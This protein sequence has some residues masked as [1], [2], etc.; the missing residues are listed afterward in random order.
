[1]GK[2][3]AGKS[4]G[5]HKL[6]AAALLLLLA[7][8]GV[9]KNTP[10]TI[11]YACDDST[12]AIIALS[13]QRDR[14]RLEIGEF[15]YDLQAIESDSGIKYSDDQILYWSKGDEAT[16]SGAALLNP[17]KCKRRDDDAS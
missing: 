3:I 16:I 14:A 12:V 8:C 11:T 5:S 1:M 10:D 7:A 13:P 17:L 15:S 6:F 2:S 4:E 9:S